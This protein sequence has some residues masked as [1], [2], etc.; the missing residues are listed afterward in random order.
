MK[1][2]IRA[3]VF[4]DTHGNTGAMIEAIRRYR[5]DVVIHLGDMERDVEPIRR[6]FADTAVYNVCG[7][8]DLFG[9][10]PEKDLVP[11]GPVKAFIT[12]GHLYNVKWGDTM[13]LAYAAQEADAQM[14]LFGHTHEALN[15]EMGSIRLINPGTAGQG[16][17]L[18]WAKIEVFENGGF[19]SEILPL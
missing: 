17:I 14:A 16:R 6:E 11:L 5:P 10:A 4:S 15:E 9:M 8:C 19:S 13:S 7:N 1:P 3:A 18:T 2:V 12:H